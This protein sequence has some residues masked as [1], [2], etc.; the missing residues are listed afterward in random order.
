MRSLPRSVSV[1][2]LCAL[3]SGCASTKLTSVWLAPERPLPV[4]K[5]V[6]VIAV[7]RKAGNRLAAERRF[8]EAFTSSGIEAVASIDIMPHDEKLAKEEV[9]AAIEGRGIDSVVVTQLQYI[10]V[11]TR[12]APGGTAIVTY[13][14]YY[15]YYQSGYVVTM[16]PVPLET[17]SDFIME[18][19]LF[20][21]ATE[22]PYWTA[23]TKTF[24]PDT[25]G[26]LITSLTSTILRQMEKDGVIAQ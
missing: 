18:T 11:Q 15:G 22:K 20:N 17:Y 5:K 25:A 10:D 6:L 9:K 7:A 16:G 19:K 3:F 8:V 21:V 24:S 26:Q 13:G 1:L 2:V 4:V 14:G 23:Q 12:M